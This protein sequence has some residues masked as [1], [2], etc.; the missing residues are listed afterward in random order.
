MFFLFVSLHNTSTTLRCR[1]NETGHTSH[2]NHVTTWV[3]HMTRG[4][5]VRTRLYHH[6]QAEGMVLSHDY[7]V[8]IN[9]LYTSYY[10]YRVIRAMPLYGRDLPGFTQSS[11][12]ST[13]LW[14]YT[15]YQL[16]MCL[17]ILVSPQPV[18]ASNDFS[19]C[20]QPFSCKLLGS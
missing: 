8:T 10:T 14:L 16:R 17:T 19:V 11:Y 13:T 2:D 18:V 5:H 3:C 6:K 12:K 20:E 15:C 4:L 1:S 7:H 9:T